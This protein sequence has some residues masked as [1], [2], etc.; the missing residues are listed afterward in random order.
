MLYLTYFTPGPGS[1]FGYG[2]WQL[3]ALI[4]F[5]IAAVKS[6]ISAVHLYA[7]CV[8]VAAIDA[9]ERLKQQ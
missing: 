2:L 7:A 3:L 4:S 9:A 6:L 1:L 5:P 8:N